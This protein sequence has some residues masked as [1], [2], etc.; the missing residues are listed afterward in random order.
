MKK[1]GMVLSLMIVFS[2]NTAVYSQTT[3]TWQDI[4]PK[5]WSG[6]FKFLEYFEGNGLLAIADN[7]YFYHSTDTAKT[8]TIE[9]S[10]VGAVWGIE[11]YPD[12]KRALIYNGKKLYR[13]TDAA[14]TWQEITLK[15]MPSDMYIHNIYIKNEDTV[16]A[17]TGNNLNGRN[18]F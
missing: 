16:F 11:V 10:P 1:F 14:K 9:P 5:G 2:C 18:I 7:G 3:P 13:T 8:W 12:R 15:G 4:T 17:C 6:D